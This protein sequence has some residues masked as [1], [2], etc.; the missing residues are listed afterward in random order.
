MR[1]ALA[2]IVVAWS[3]WRPELL[4]MTIGTLVAGSAGYVALSVAGEIARRRFVRRG[5]LSCR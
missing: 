2:A 5:H 4:G 1:V 3:A